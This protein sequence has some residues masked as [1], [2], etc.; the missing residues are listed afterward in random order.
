[1][2]DLISQV[3]AGDTAAWHRLWSAVQPTVWAITGNWR[4]TG[5]VS[6]REEDRKNIAVDV[7]ERLRADDCRRLR[8][9]LDGA[10]RRPGS[11]FK[12]WLATV[13]A[14]AA[15]DYVRAHPEFDDGRGTNR[16]PRWFRVVPTANVDAGAATDRDPVLRATAHE[17]LDRAR[18]DLEPKQLSALA[19]WLEGRS[20]DEIAS[21]L[22]LADGGEADRLVRAALKRL[23]DRFAGTMEALEGST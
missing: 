10:R 20:H 5:A 23:R 8:A 4:I 9:Y 12:A 6:R 7:M 19:H 21:R 17:L 3:I 13:T 11:S 15:I 16:E 2:D 18:R 14:R 1:M 22:S